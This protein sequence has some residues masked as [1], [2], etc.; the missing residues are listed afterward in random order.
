MI[1]FNLNLLYI[2][3][4][5]CLAA[6][7]ICLG[8]YSSSA[9]AALSISCTPEFPH[10]HYKDKCP[11]GE[12]TPTYLQNGSTYHVIG[13]ALTVNDPS[14]LY[15]QP[16]SN[17]LAGFY[18]PNAET[19]LVYCDCG[20]K[21]M[22]CRVSVAAPNIPGRTGSFGPNGNSV[23]A[24][25]ANESSSVVKFT[26]TLDPIPPFQLSASTS[27]DKPIS[28]AGD[29]VT[30]THKINKVSG[31]F[32]SQ[33]AISWTGTPTR[34]GP[35]YSYAYSNALERIRA[36]RN[37]T[38]Q[39]NRYLA[40]TNGKGYAGGVTKVTI[41]K[42]TPP[43]TKIC[44]KTS[45]VPANNKL[46]TYTGN[47][48]CTTVSGF[49]FN[50]IPVVE[51]DK[52]G[53]AEPGEDV[54][55]SYF[56]QNTKEQSS[57]VDWRTYVLKVKPGVDVAAITSGSLQEGMAP[58]EVAGLL[59]E[60]GGV[61]NASLIDVDKLKGARAFPASARTSVSTDNYKIPVNAE[62]G[63]RYCFLLAVTP[64][65]HNPAPKNR[66]SLA[67]CITVGIKSR[68]SI[69]GGD[70][71]VGRHFVDDPTASKKIGSTIQ[72]STVTKGAPNGIT[73]GSWSEYGAYAPGDIRGFGTAAGLQG[74]SALSTQQS[75]SKLTFANAGTEKG[76]FSSSNTL[77]FIP[78]SAR[79]IIEHIPLARS[80]DTTVNE[81]TIS[82]ANS[83]GRYEK[84][85]GDLTLNASTIGK[86][87]SVVV[88]VPNGRVT[89]A[90]NL[91]YP[92]GRYATSKDLPQL[93]IIAK[94]ITINASVTSVNAWL[95]AK[96]PTG[97]SAVADEAKEEVGV[98]K[99]CEV[100]PP[101][102]ARDCNRQLTVNG[103]VMA[104]QLLLRRTGAR[105][106]G[107]NVEPAE[108]F[109]LRA[110]AYLWLYEQK[111]G[112]MRALTTYTRELPVRF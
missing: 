92:G 76:K 98:I 74:G 12:G 52:N 29:L 53:P 90:G 42:D 107:V 69:Y 86:G 15:K 91:D 4:A 26:Y 33:D 99:T 41:Q 21:N 82:E 31:T 50:L 10:G 8:V 105:A 59:G 110:D 64:P 55:V 108:T 20:G 60:T 24:G 77:G 51:R 111:K 18:I 38:Q 2:S 25:G 112:A 71:Q 37:K 102:T 97:A 84:A 106:G 85:T 68:I 7:A 104:N 22:K 44:Y 87:K 95:V 65:T 16:V 14:G 36:D 79:A 103:P 11:P 32:L 58:E 27:V 5:A 94:N 39:D 9:S 28:R 72:A 93:V 54:L 13:V 62:D 49:D 73:Y 47:D 66:H 109:N 89:I 88:F 80:I 43:G 30:F 61:S 63:E 81:M 17:N 83:A 70:L 1:R 3:G 48:V 6:V 23:L 46:G 78:D 57:P 40:T 45:V 96:Y 101:L 56:V 19:G 100:E 75:W 34:E 35:L 67:S